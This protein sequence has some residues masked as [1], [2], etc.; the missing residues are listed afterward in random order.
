MKNNK[1]SSGECNIVGKK[2][3]IIRKRKGIN[4]QTLSVALLEKGIRLSTS[5]ISKIE[6]CTRKVSDIELLAISQILGVSVDD[7]LN[8]DNEEMK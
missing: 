2:L 4:Q 6:N 3:G 7:L 5:S 1:I 8:H